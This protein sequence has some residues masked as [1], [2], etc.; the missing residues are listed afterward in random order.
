MNVNL[1]RVILNGMVFA[2]VSV[3]VPIAT[4]VIS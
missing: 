3:L 2:V 1:L 4:F